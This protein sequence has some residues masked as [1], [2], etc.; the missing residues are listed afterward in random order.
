MTATVTL[1]GT[2]GVDMFN[3]FPALDGVTAFVAP[4]INAANTAAA[5]TF[6]YAGVT[7]GIRYSGTGLSLS[8]GGDIAGSVSQI[9]LYDT[10][11]PTAILANV[12]LSAP[13]AM[14]SAI[15]LSY[16]TLFTSGDTVNGSA[17]GDLI[18]AGDG[19]HETLIGGAGSDTFYFSYLNTSITDGQSFAG[20][21]I[22]GGL[23]AGE[24]NTL[25]F[26]GLTGGLSTTYDTRGASISGIN[27]I[28]TRW[29]TYLELDWSQLAPNTI[30]IDTPGGAF[31]HIHDS[32]LTSNH[33][34]DGTQLGFQGSDLYNNGAPTTWYKWGNVAIP[35]L[36]LDATGSNANVTI[37]APTAV[38]SRLQGG[39]GNDTLIANNQV[40]C[41]VNG[42]GGSDTIN[43]AGRT[44][45]DYSNLTSGIVARYGFGSGTVTKN[46]GGTDTI[47]NASYFVGSSGSDTFF[48]VQGS[49]NAFD[50]GGGNGV[51]TLDLSSFT[52]DTTVYSHYGAG[53]FGA[54]P[55]NQNYAGMFNA[56]R[57]YNI[58]LGAGNDT[59]TMD[60]PFGYAN[61]GGGTNTVEV[62]TTYI[63]VGAVNTLGGVQLQNFQ[64]INNG[65][66][67]SIATQ[68]LGTH[69]FT[70]RM[71][72]NDYF[73]GT[74]LSYTNLVARDLTF[75]QT[76]QLTG[77]YTTAVQSGAGTV[78]GVGLND[79]YTGFSRLVGG[80]GNDIFYTYTTGNQG[81]TAVDGG[82]GYNTLI[83]LANNA[84]LIIGGGS[85]KNIRSLYLGGGT[86]TVSVADHDAS[87]YAIN[88]F[89]YLY[90]GGAGST[91]TMTLGLGGGYLNAN[92]GTNH[93]YGGSGSWSGLSVGSAANATNYFVGGLGVSDMHGGDG[94]NIYNIGL[95]DTVAGA[96]K[97]NTVNLL[98]TDV[99]LTNA[100][101]LTH[102]NQVNLK[103]G[104]N[105]VDMT[106]ATEILILN[107]AAGNDTLIGGTRNDTLN[108]GAGNDTLTGGLG[109][110]TLLGGSGS[111]TANYTV[112]STGATF[113][114][115]SQAA[116]GWTITQGTEVDTLSTIEIARFSNVDVTLRQARANF[117]F[118]ATTNDA[119]ATS[120][121][122]LLDAN[123]YV[124]DW[125]I[126]NKAFA[127]GS[128]IGGSA[129]WTV[130]TTGDFNADGVAD[131]LMR[132]NTNNQVSNWTVRD[133]VFLGS[134]LVSGNASGW[135]LVGT[136]DVN[137]DGS[138]DVVMQRTD[139]MV[140]VWVMTGGVPTGVAIGLASGYTAAAIGDFNGDG[141]A[142]ILLRNNSTGALVGWMMN[143]GAIQSGTSVA[144]GA[145]LTVA[146]AGDFDAD[147]TTDILLRDGSNNLYTLMMQNGVAIGS[148][149]I[150]NVGAS[151]VVGTGDYNGD[152]TADIAL[153]NGGTLNIF[154]I[155]N[156]L[157][158][159]NTLVSNGIGGYSVIG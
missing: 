130:F 28:Y 22:Q 15:N 148:H 98:A 14:T 138:S 31:T 73:I 84:N 64:S 61:G 63:S 114:H 18:I 101:N 92:G 85:V 124:I 96:G 62:V 16:R 155:N 78:T 140:G 11:N 50:G 105:T 110:D 65:Q 77:K 142:D 12:V 91:N 70:D 149:L 5:G 53:I 8:A 51:D 99:T 97:Y 141:T 127:A 57:I 159:N 135:G 115:T 80:V 13:L 145:G 107:G 68:E 3:L 109:N 125:T 44:V 72:I 10:A 32:V 144:N 93:M 119:G 82:A 150:G 100:V 49:N 37:I 35:A 102:V 69:V 153:Q 19:G 116:N 95:N 29:G 108:G 147:G 134:N 7:Y 158:V 17:G 131:I 137:N 83:D 38:W 94:T 71:S 75:T 9:E 27:Q 1:A 67:A 118:G 152:G 151:A 45:V 2:S 79:S 157:F 26:Q 33:T 112:A 23:G 58:K 156:G 21:V 113:R 123:G 60:S 56:W 87:L 132:N 103:G 74:S 30:F 66:G 48:G 54:L 120:D 88:D 20:N 40:D 76:A 41:V 104:T 90:G 47:T 39:S 86:N 146:G 52:A 4:T 24:I 59:L 81:S 117:N 136:G 143:N 128:L 34:I 154:Q 6:T 126:Q 25:Y 129:G 42:S 133:G 121:L 139:G 106:G 89:I 36:W 43:G 46:S 55:S 122:L 111:D